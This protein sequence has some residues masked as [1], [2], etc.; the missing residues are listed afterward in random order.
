MGGAVAAIESGWMQAEIQRSSWTYQQDVESG[1]E[2]VVGV[3]RYRSEG[4]DPK[5]IFRVDPRLGQAQ[6][7]RLTSIRGERDRAGVDT[8]L[9]RLRTAAEGTDNLMPPIIDA[10][11]SYATLG[12]ICGVLRDVFGDYRA[13][14]AV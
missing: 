2:V 4:E 6:M 12:E 14:T 11:K 10:V 13:P 3:N 1:R 9:T 7:S 8:A 5:L